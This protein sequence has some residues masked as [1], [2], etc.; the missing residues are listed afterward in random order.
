MTPLRAALLAV[1]AGLSVGLVYLISSPKQRTA[2]PATSARRVHAPA[3]TPVRT[4]VAPVQAGAAADE[5]PLTL[6]RLVVMPRAAIRPL[7]IAVA[8]VTPQYAGPRQR[9]PENFRGL[10]DTLLLVQLDAGTK[11]VRTLSFPRDTRI[12][13]PGG[14]FMKLNA[15]LPTFGPDGLRQVLTDVSGVPID[16]YLLLGLN[17]SR[18]LTD[19]LGGVRVVVPKDMYYDDR[20]AGLHIRL[21]R[22]PQRLNG[23][24][25]EGFVRFRHDALGDLG[26]VQRQQ[27]FMRAVLAEMLTPA[28]LT[29][30]PA[31]GG[32]LERNTRSNVTSEH[33]AAAFDLLRQRPK[34]ESFT[35]PGTFENTGGA[36]YWVADQAKV[37]AL[38]TRHFA[39]GGSVDSNIGA[40]ALDVAIVDAG[41]GTM[42]ALRVRDLLRARGYA[43]ARI[44]PADSEPG[45]TIILGQH[46]IEDLERVRA[47]LGRGES[48]LSGEGVLG[49]D[50]TI[51]LGTDAR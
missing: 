14:G 2:A 47:V 26:R 20:A 9:L 42:A 8:G 45:T 51:W 25:A 28:G 30:L 16:A 4:L 22:G 43:R 10:T 33:L 27:A 6:G 19:A 7:N 11:T 34:L 40:A 17:A 5:Q 23:E 32:V 12:T 15:A 37:A 49:A 46:D 21:K 36:S 24:Q 50:I 31:L 1:A 29:R 48:R 13:R 35:L 41:A 3:Q 38:F 44:A 39:A 18:Q